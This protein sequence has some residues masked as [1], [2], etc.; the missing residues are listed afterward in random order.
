[1]SATASP[2]QPRLSLYYYDSCPFCRMVLQELA[3]L[4]L[5]VERRNTLQDRKHLQDLVSGGGKQTVP[6]LLIEAD[7]NSTWMYESRDIIAYLNSLAK[8]LC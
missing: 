3:H 7:G 1:M 8:L 2:S 5:E 6:C 4:N